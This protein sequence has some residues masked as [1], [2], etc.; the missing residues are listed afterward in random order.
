MRFHKGKYQVQNSEKYVG[1]KAPIFRSSWENT[2][3]RM[4]DENENI[5]RWGSECVEIPYRSPLDNRWH[6]YYPDF[7]CKIKNKSGTIDKLIIEVKPEKQTKP[8]K[9]D[10]NLP[11]SVR[12]IHADS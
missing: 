4:C 12:L 10:K 1:N 8:P 5:T 7:M 9:T 11:T 3:C 2:F 6:K